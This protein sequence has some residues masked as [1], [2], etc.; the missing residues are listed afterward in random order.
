[1][2]ILLLSK[3]LHRLRS[4][5]KRVKSYATIAATSLFFLHFF[6]FVLYRPASETV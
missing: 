4:E 6:C 1:M 5:E 3:A 2:I